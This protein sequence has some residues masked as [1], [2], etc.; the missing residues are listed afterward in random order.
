MHGMEQFLGI[1][2][3]KS[4]LRDQSEEEG[5]EEEEEEGGKHARTSRAW[6]KAALWAASSAFWRSSSASWDA[7]RA[8][9]SAS[10]AAKVA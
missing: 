7:L 1:K 3:A 8:A 2:K 6:F 10:V 4:R 5:I 9:T